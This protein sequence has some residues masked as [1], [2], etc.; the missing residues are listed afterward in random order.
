MKKNY[1]LR[2]LLKEFQ[3]EQLIRKPYRDGELVLEYVEGYEVPRYIIFFE[4]GDSESEDTDGEIVAELD[5]RFFDGKMA[6]MILE[7]IMTR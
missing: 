2:R 7:Y 6:E 3:F 1:T 5:S 4:S